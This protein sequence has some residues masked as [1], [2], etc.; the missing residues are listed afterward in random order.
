MSRSTLLVIL[1]TTSL[2]SCG[3]GSP[4][5][6]IREYS[7]SYI[8]GTPQSYL[9]FG[10]SI[11]GR[12]TGGPIAQLWHFDGVR[13]IR[14]EAVILTDFELENRYSRN[15]GSTRPV[16]QYLYRG[17]HGISIRFD[18]YA[19][20]V[21][22]PVLVFSDT[23]RWTDA[24]MIDELPSEIQLTRE[25][26]EFD[27]KTL[28]RTYE[29]RQLLA[30]LIEGYGSPE[31]AT[32]VRRQLSRGYLRGTG[33]VDFTRDFARS[34]GLHEVERGRTIDLLPAT[35]SQGNVLRIQLYDT[36][37]TERDEDSFYTPVVVEDAS[38]DYTESHREVDYTAK[39]L[40]IR[41]RIVN[42]RSVFA[43]RLRM[44]HP[45]PEESASPRDGVSA[46]P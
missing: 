19:S 25:P 12:S 44:T 28:V 14:H 32:R 23:E 3:P 24:T 8:A 43:L 45:P 11:D 38:K 17:R 2:V 22:Q 7:G 41:R 35:D 46:A 13:R 10:C 16:W 29:Q 40:D 6:L 27:P 15:Y 4:K 20:G 36:T 37:I 42:D 30:T 18:E 21:I 5:S 34:L 26:P 31:S 33:H 9:H 39:L 1:V